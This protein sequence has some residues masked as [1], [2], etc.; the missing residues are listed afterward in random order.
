MNTGKTQ[1]DSRG[2]MPSVDPNMKKKTRNKSDT[3]NINEIS[4]EMIGK[5]N[6]H[7]SEDLETCQAE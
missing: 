5:E 7:F 2:V 4:N 3:D 1:H 6:C